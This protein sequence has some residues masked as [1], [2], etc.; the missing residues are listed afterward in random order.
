VCLDSESRAG[1]EL[2]NGVGEDL[3]ELSRHLEVLDRAAVDADEVVVVVV[4]VVVV[5]A[6]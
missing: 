1:S 2:A 4:V 5:T 3:L 6:G